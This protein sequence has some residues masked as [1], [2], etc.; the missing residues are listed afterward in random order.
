[1]VDVEK[2]LVMCESFEPSTAFG[3]LIELYGEFKAHEEKL[4]HVAFEYALPEMAIAYQKSKTDCQS[5]KSK[6]FELWENSEN[7]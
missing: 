1:M 5:I 4:R 6:I 7:T 3:I 2:I